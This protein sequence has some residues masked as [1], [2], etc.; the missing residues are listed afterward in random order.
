[1]QNDL[2]VKARPWTERQSGRLAFL[3]FLR[4]FAF[5]SV[6]IGH[7]LYPDLA[8]LIS[9]QGVHSTIRMIAEFLMPLCIG[10]GAG[11][12]VFFLVSGYIISHVITKEDTAAFVVK[13]FFRIYPL[14]ILAVVIEALLGK[15]AHGTPWPN[16]SEVIPRI[17]LVGDFFSVPYALAGVEWTLRIE[18]MFYILIAICRLLRITERPTFLITVYALVTIFMQAFGPFSTGASHF[19]G[20]ITL[21]M[22]FLFMGS[23]F[24]LY[25]KERPK[26]VV[27][28]GLYIFSSHLIL[29]PLINPGYMNSNFAAYG[30]V[31]FLMAWRLRDVISPSP[32]LT[33]FSE[34]TYSV[35]L[36][37]N[38]LWQYIDVYVVKSDPSFSG[39]VKIAMILL[40]ICALVH[41]ICEKRFVKIGAKMSQKFVRISGG[42]SASQTDGTGPVCLTRSNHTIS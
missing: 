24:Y 38:W 16:L 4:V 6:L 12:V 41:E 2:P 40:L 36:L 3:D 34:L 1:M 9:N 15:V 11:V 23:C 28:L 19:K 7:K 5:A 8:S 27:T 26:G 35:Y 14:F 22:P 37:H 25:E 18:I 30:C 42:A 29:L 17:L 33:F 20:Y 13:R 32:L 10:G 39:K 31:L 21:Y